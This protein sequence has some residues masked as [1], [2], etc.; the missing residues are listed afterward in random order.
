MPV[1]FALMD[2]TR[3]AAWIGWLCFFPALFVVWLI[4]STRVRIFWR[5]VWLLVIF[6]SICPMSVFLIYNSGMLTPRI[7]QSV[8]FDGHHYYFTTQ[9]IFEHCYY[10]YYFYRCNKKDTK[11]VKL[12]TWKNMDVGPADGAIDVD[13]LKQEVHL[14]I[15]PFNDPRL[16]YTSDSYSHDYRTLDIY[17]SHPFRYYLYSFEKDSVQEFVITRCDVAHWPKIPCEFIPFQY[18]VASFSRGRLEG[19]EDE[20]PGKFQLSID[21]KE[22]LSYDG[23]PH[24]LMEGCVVL[25]E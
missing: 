10:D 24:C 13:P 14:F 20:H 9:K 12:Y 15:R 7:D 8:Q 3:L 4:F 5:K 23:S 25:D 11:C 6:L 1:S 22:I 2:A 21:Y 16:A 19:D 17:S 18:S